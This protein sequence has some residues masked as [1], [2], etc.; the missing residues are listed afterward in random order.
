MMNTKQNVSNINTKYTTSLTFDFVRACENHLSK[1]VEMSML[2]AKVSWQYLSIE[3]TSPSR[4]GLQICI[5]L[6][7]CST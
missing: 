2:A 1:R 6:S 4:G 5:H 3:T 7:H